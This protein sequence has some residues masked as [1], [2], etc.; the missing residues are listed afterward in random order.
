[1][2]DALTDLPN[3]LLLNDRLTGAIALAERHNKPLA[4]LFL[5]VDGF[6]AVNDS[7]GHAVG[8]ALLRSIATRLKAA[9]AARIP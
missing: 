4:V 7:L 6:K 8:D 5:D 3:R 2:H 9:V 1:V